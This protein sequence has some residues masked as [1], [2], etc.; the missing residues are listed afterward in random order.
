MPLVTGWKRSSDVDGEQ[1]PIDQVPQLGDVHLFFS[2]A[3]PR[4]NRLDRLR[5]G[6]GQ[7]RRRTRRKQDQGSPGSLRPTMLKEEAGT[8]HTLAADSPEV[9]A[10]GRIWQ[11]E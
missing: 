11:E 3:G 1:L 2:G 5:K 7:E 6:G 9:V 4:S 10:G 8:Q